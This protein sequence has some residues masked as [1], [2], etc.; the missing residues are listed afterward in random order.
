MKAL[1]LAAAGLLVVI[2]VRPASAADM[3]MPLKAPTVPVYNWT[4]LYIG[5]N[6]GGGWGQTQFT[7][8][9]NFG[10]VGSGGYGSSG[11][12]GGGQI[13]FNYQFSSNWV[14]GVEADAD[15]ASITG[16]S[17]GCVTLGGVGVTGCSSSNTKLGD[18]GTVR[19]RLGY[20][21]NNMLLYGTGGWAWSRSSSTSSVTCINPGGGC[22]GLS[23]IAPSGQGS[24]TIT[25][26]GWTAGA[27]VE[28]GFLPN[29]TVRVEYQHLEFD[30]AGTNYTFLGAPVVIGPLSAHTQTNTGS[31]TVRLGVNYRFDWGTNSAAGRY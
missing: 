13:G 23:A 20:A 8:A 16:L 3:S 25:P 1:L 22:P 6:F 24:A 14:A 15:W 2:A 29:W 11:T 5:A 31:D 17:S 28:W 19:G 4:G 7:L 10:E 27:G 12:F 30:N 9:D 21:W 26:P 18:F